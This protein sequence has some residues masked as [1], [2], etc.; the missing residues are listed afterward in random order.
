VHGP[1]EP[2]CRS[3]AAALIAAAI[4][5]AATPCRGQQAQRIAL[6]NDTLYLSLHDAA[7]AGRER[8]PLSISAGARARE[9]RAQVGT[10]RS[11]SSA[12]SRIKTPAHPSPSTSWM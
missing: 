6:L 5:V 12:H 2:H 4:I 10:A 3:A 11:E 1:T 9:A 7:I 8:S